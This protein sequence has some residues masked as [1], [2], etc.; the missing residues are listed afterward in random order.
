MK[1][2]NR[3]AWIILALAVLAAGSLGVLAGYVAG[4]R[5]PHSQCLR[6]GVSV[7]IEKGLGFLVIGIR[8]RF[9]CLP[10]RLP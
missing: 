6:L 7:C 9:Q 3:T 2:A 10:S 4:S 5:N 1:I 8:M